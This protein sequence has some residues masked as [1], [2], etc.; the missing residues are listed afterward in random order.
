MPDTRAPDGVQTV[1]RHGRGA[2]RAP[3]MAPC[4]D[5]SWYPNQAFAW[6]DAQRRSWI[7]RTCWRA[8]RE[9]TRGHVWS[10]GAAFPWSLTADKTL[11]RLQTQWTA[12]C[13]TVPSRACVS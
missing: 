13:G 8:G 1:T 3:G 11:A 4:G 2:C 7:A 9:K 5:L 10:V 6:S 12:V